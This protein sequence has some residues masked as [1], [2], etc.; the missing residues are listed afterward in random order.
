MGK[1][2]S[3]IPDD[4]PMEDKLETDKQ[5]DFPQTWETNCYVKLDLCSRYVDIFFPLFSPDDHAWV[6]LTLGQEIY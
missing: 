6:M 5:S 1:W 3:S 4:V 2:E